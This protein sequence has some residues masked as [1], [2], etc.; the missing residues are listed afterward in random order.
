MTDYLIPPEE[1]EKYLKFYKRRQE[2]LDSSPELRCFQNK[3]DLTMKEIGSNPIDRCQVI[4][5]I[6]LQSA[7]N[8]S[9]KFDEVIEDIKTLEM[10]TNEIKEQINDIK[11]RK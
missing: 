6:M 4:Q 11:E 9:Q 10:K 3:I 5:T 7:Y 2:L 1:M 8:L